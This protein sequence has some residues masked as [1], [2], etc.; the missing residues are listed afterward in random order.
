M[1]SGPE[2]LAAA[3]RSGLPGP[4]GAAV[5]LPLDITSPAATVPPHLRRAVIIRDRHCAFP[6]CEH[7]PARCH[8][9][10]VIPRSQG[11]PT[12]LH[13]LVLICAFHHL[14]VIHRRGWTLAL[15]ADGTTTAASPDRRKVLHSHSYAPPG[16][17][18]A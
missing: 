3:L 16:T 13:N 11:G 1:L 2:G 12:A 5:S 18:A 7:E 4:L 17:A 15:H 8:V 14:N 9:H 6:G 10:H